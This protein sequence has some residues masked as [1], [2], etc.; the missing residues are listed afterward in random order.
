MTPGKTRVFLVHRDVHKDRAKASV[1]GYYVL[2]R[3]EVIAET[4]IA[5]NL[6]RMNVDQLWPKNPEPYLA[7]VERCR[8]IN[9]FK[10]RN[11]DRIEK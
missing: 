9:L 1:F 5:T 8:E 3:I 7:L 11:Q 4:N 10:K 6:S 2:H